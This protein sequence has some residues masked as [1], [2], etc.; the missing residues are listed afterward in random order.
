VQKLITIYK[1]S[2]LKGIPVRGLRTLV[3][4]RILS[5]Y[6]LGHRTMLFSPE[7]V[8]RELQRFEVKSAFDRNGK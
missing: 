4:K 5:H 8:E 3:Q 7:K 2:E 1:L 6:K